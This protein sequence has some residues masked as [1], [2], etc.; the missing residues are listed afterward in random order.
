MQFNLR[1][2]LV[3]TLMLGAAPLAAQEANDDSQPA[4]EEA[5]ADPGQA[6]D[7]GTPVDANGNEA[8]QPYFREEFGDWRVRCIA[9]PDGEDPC[10]LY[11]LLTGPDGN[12]VAEFSLVPITNGGEAVAGA[13]VIVPLE[14]QLTE[15]LVLS[16][17]GGQ[18]RRYE[19][20][21][22]NQ[23]GCVARFGLTQDQIAGFQNGAAGQ[24]TI[25]PAAA[26]DQRVDLTLSLTGFTAGFAWVTE[27]PT[28]E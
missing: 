17:D 9:N 2:V 24:V 25:V 27:N 10:Q 1:H 11:Q 4:T 13:T 12:A 28:A 3:A 16:V 15:R 19:Y 18:A 14:T 23:G 20:T 7:L 26:P 6:L 21:F 22:C 5:P 8:G